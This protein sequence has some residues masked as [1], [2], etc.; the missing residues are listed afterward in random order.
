MKPLCAV[1]LVLMQA[2]FLLAQDKVSPTI[3]KGTTLTY[4]VSANG[5]SFPIQM[6]VDSISSDYARFN[7]SM[8]DGSSGTA[9]NTKASLDNAVHGFWGELHSGEDQTMP[10]DQSIL[11]LSKALWSSIQKDKK[12]RFDEQDYVIKEQPTASVFK[13]NDKP[14]NALYA[15]SSN[16]SVRLWFLNNPSI[17]ILLKIEGNPLGVDVNLQSVE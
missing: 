9:I 1:L 10:A 17:P 4:L 16:G 7:W 11:I 12:F 5:Q 8:S 2:S 15:E 6:R 14:V 3:K 13:I